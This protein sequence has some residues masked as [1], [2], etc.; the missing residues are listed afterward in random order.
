ML[1][2]YRGFS[3]GSV[4]MSVWV[5]LCGY[6]LFSALIPLAR[7][8]ARDSVQSEYT[9]RET[10]PHKH[11]TSVTKTKV[12]SGYKSEARWQVF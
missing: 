1:R 9:E 4:E 11:L 8:S 10:K 6:S 2:N 5:T 12:S 3:S 7:D